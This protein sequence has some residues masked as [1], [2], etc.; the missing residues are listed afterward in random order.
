[1]NSFDQRA[2]HQ[3][4][5]E[6]LA[7]TGESMMVVELS[8]LNG[9]SRDEVEVAT[10]ELVRRGQIERCRGRGRRVRLV[11]KPCG[12]EGLLTENHCEPTIWTREKQSYAAI[13]EKL[14]REWMPRLGFSDVEVTNTAHQGRRDTGGIWSRQYLLG[15]GTHPTLRRGGPTRHV[16]TF[17]V[18]LGDQFDVRAIHEAHAQRIHLDASAAFLLVVVTQNGIAN[19]ISKHFKRLMRHAKET[20]VGLVLLAATPTDLTWLPLQMPREWSAVRIARSGL[21]KN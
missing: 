1:M 14:Q 6:C 12:F 4:I 15:S 8:L 16:V 18:K 21:L 7:A 3:L 17:E 19:A 10:E 20:N 11:R 13:Q 2:H 5:T 9:L